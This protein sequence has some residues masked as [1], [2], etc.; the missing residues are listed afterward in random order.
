MK[1]EKA[2]KCVENTQD[3]KF[4]KD[5]KNLTFDGFCKKFLRSR[6]LVTSSVS[7]QLASYARYEEC[8]TEAKYFE[9]GSLGFLKR[10]LS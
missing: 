3:I 2:R 8:G 4:C 1:L 10:W 5:C 9:Q 6:N 7:Y